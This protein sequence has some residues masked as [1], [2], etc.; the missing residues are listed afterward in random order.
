MI[1]ALDGGH[2]PGRVAQAGVV[3]GALVH[4][5]A[6]RRDG[7]GVFR[8]DLEGAVGGCLVD[9]EHAVRL[10]DRDLLELHLAAL[11]PRGDRDGLLGGREHQ[12][13]VLVGVEARE[14]DGE[15]EAVGDGCRLSHAVGGGEQLVDEVVHEGLGGGRCIAFQGRGV[16]V[17]VHWLHE[18]G[19]GREE[20]VGGLPSEPPEPYARGPPVEHA[21]REGV[22]GRGVE[23]EAP[24][25]RDV[26]G[27]AREGGRPC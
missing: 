25:V 6:P 24:V 20:E 9:I 27:R 4:D 3:G 22:D 21:G 17:L 13:G 16:A 1:P 7:V 23:V 15:A 12:V 14:L 11:S 2:A 26:Q 5:Q 10:A 8:R 18:A 19:F